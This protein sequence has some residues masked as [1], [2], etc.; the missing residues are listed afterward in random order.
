MKS[1]IEGDQNEND[2]R[3]TTERLNLIYPGKIRY[4]I[5]STIQENKSSEEEKKREKE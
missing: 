5:E 1:Q 3:E 2:L 4:E